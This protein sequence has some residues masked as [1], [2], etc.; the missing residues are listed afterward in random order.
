MNRDAGIVESDLFEPGRNCWRVSHATRLSYLID[1][2]AFFQAFRT[3]ARR[4]QRTIYLLG[5]DIH[6]GFELLR[7]SDDGMPARLGEFLDALARQRKGLEIHI[8]TWDFTVLLSLHREWAARYRLG[9]QT[10]DNVR[11]A[12]D[13]RYPFGGSHHQKVVVIDDVLGFVG[14]LDF[15]RG[16]W[17]TPQHLPNDPRRADYPGHQPKPYHDVQLLVAGE[18]AADLGELCR[19]R[20]GWATGEEL[21]DPRRSGG[22][23][24]DWSACWPEG[25]DAD[26]EDCPVAVVRTLP[27]LDDREPV[28]E[29]V[30]EVQQ[31]LVDAIGR[32]QRHIFIENQYFT[33]PVL[34]DA[35]A[36]RLAD[37]NGPEV[38]VVVPYETEGWLSQATMDVLRERRLV[39]LQKADRHGRLRV[40]FPHHPRLGRQCINVHSK[41]L[42]VDDDLMCAGSANLNNRSLALDSECNLAVES[43]GDD[44]RRQGIARLRDR[45]LAE[46]LGVPPAEVARALAREGSLIAAIER[47]RGSGRTLRTLELRVSEELDAS[48]PETALTDPE[49]AIDASYI[50]S[51]LIPRGVVRFAWRGAAGIAAVIL[52]A[53]L[54]AAAW[55]W[56]PLG[57]WVDPG[58]ML[59]RFS[60]LRGSWSA[61]LLVAAIFVLGGFLMIPVTVLIVAAGLAF[62]AAWGFSYALLGAELSALAAYG[63]GHWLGHDTIRRLSGLGVA[64]ASRFVGRQGLLAVITLRIVPVAPFTIVNFV[65]GASHIRLREFAIGTLLGMVPGTLVLTVLSDQVAAAVR[66]P[67]LAGVLTALAVLAL[68]VLG[69]WALGRW[70]KGK[71]DAR[72]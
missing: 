57:E 54:L 27:G 2:Q 18:V 19:Q 20:W 4:A 7:D 63:V 40:Y 35:L 69:S 23:A 36:E 43:G 15:T 12:F 66:S 53:V 60:G 17:D 48:V 61:P 65:A 47:L 58:A 39:E 52:A 16:R 55:R 21:P 33:A 25:V 8:L 49:H 30:R 42:V 46:H 31:L 11:F 38:V 68:G 22:P 14:G 26:L 5:W 45:L 3:A 64:R 59:E 1:G 29:P 50:A 32:A 72:A 28:R 56:T 24:C 9:W 62:G 13:D 10:H 6:S 34:G 70:L 51:Q 44:A 71:Q 41:V 37:E 67:D